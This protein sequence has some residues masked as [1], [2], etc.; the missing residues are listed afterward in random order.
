MFCYLVF[1]FLARISNKSLLVRQNLLSSSAARNC[2]QIKVIWYMVVPMVARTLKR[3]SSMQKSKNKQPQREKYILDKEQFTRHKCL[4]VLQVFNQSSPDIKMQVSV[5]M[6][7]MPGKFQSDMKPPCQMQHLVRSP[8]QASRNR[9]SAMSHA[10]SKT[11]GYI[12]LHS[13]IG[14]I[15]KDKNAGCNPSSIIIPKQRVR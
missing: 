6:G 3:V 13:V 14:V 12:A 8:L 15:F 10:I 7:G 11:Q 1:E 2:H 5:L 4:S 9:V